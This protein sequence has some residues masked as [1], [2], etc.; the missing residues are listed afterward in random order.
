MATLIAVLC[1]ICFSCYAEATD[2][3]G[4]TLQGNILL[5]NEVKEIPDGS[6][7]RVKLQDTMLADAAAKT[8]LQQK[9]DK[10]DLKVENGTVG[11]ILELKGDLSDVNEYTISVVVNMG[12][13]AEENGKEWI[14]KGDLLNDTQ[15]KV[16][17]KECPKDDKLC[18]GP[19]V[20]L[21]KT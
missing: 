11:Y 6:C 17:L 10:P 5:P 4:K 9:V 16:Q 1:V 7:M 8:L 3:T 20:S 21:I 14:R 12:W 18:K 13:C 15:F 19:I 2:Y